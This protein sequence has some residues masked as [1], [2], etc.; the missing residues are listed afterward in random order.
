MSDVPGFRF[1]ENEAGREKLIGLGRYPE[2]SLKAARDRRDEARRL[3][4]TSVDPAEKRRAERLAL[5]DT[6]EA[7]A[8]EFL[9]LKSKS[10]NARTFALKT[11]RLDTFIFPR[12]GAQ[13]ITK[14]NSGAAAERTAT[15]RGTRSARDC[16]SCTRS[17]Q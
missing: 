9:A 5:P 10:L 14:V 7:I 13:P 2:V 15:D 4:A 6:F 16:T 3:L 1:S 12:I 11:A 17:M 8:R